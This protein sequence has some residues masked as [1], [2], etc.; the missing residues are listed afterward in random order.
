MFKKTAISDFD[1]FKLYIII[2]ILKRFF[3]YNLS[4]YGLIE[5]S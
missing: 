5:D 3:L 1:D 2:I 4:K